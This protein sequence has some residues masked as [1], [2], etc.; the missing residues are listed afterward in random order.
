MQSTLQTGWRGDQD[1]KLLHKRRSE[2]D[3]L[4]NNLHGLSSDLPFVTRLPHVSGC[5]G[6]G[7]Y[8]PVCLSDGD[9]CL[10]RPLVCKLVSVCIN[11]WRSS[12]FSL[13]IKS[14]RQWRCLTEL[15]P[16]SYG[17]FTQF[18]ESWKQS[19][20]DSEKPCWS[21]TSWPPVAAALSTLRGC[22]Y[23]ALWMSHL[24]RCPLYVHQ[25]YRSPPLG[26]APWF[27]THTLP[28]HHQ[29]PPLWLLQIHHLCL[30]PA[31]WVPFSCALLH[32]LRVKNCFCCF[33]FRC[34]CSGKVSSETGSLDLNVALIAAVMFEIF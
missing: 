27:T 13:P 19:A 17:Q 20:S 25:I 11:I 15:L 8:P 24:A 10:F 16:G 14:N 12:L 34:T 4:C 23:R 5:P 1:R 28:L 3:I 29:L 9:T 33:F 6:L 18:N 22:I 32:L 7:S 26:R 21:R 31:D 30:Q 2:F